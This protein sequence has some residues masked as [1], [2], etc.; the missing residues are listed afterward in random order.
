MM[1]IL[2]KTEFKGYF[3]EPIVLGNFDYNSGVE[4]C[5]IILLGISGGF[6]LLSYLL[7]LIKIKI[8]K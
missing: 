5:Y 7:L 6:W 8:M 1:E 4:D 2:I 3:W